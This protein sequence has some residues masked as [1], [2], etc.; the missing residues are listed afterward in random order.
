MSVC[1]DTSLEMSE[2][3]GRDATPRAAETGPVI[4]AVSETRAVEGRVRAVHPPP[5][6][7]R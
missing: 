3:C 6:S 4:G 5:R 1:M 7:A 2:G